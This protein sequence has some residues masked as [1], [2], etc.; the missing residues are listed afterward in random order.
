MSLRA[1]LTAWA[2]AVLSATCALG[3]TTRPAAGVFSDAWL[4]E[5]CL[6]ELKTFSATGEYEVLGERMEKAILGRLGCGRLGKLSALTDM[7]YVLSA[8]RHLPSADEELASWLLDHREVSRR[9]LRALGDVRSAKAS[10]GRLKE[11]VDADEKS[12]LAY[13][14]LAVAFAT[15]EPLKHY[16]DQ[17]APASLVDCFRYYTKARVRFRYDLRKMPY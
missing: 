1:V 16:R 17:P 8:C 6:A 5:I 9:L 12:V 2:I 10:F 7:V 14:E 3:Q 13:P 15:A 11:L 4:S